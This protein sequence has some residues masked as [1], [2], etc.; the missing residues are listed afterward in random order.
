MLHLESS[1]SFHIVP[2][3]TFVSD[4]SLAPAKPDI[5]YGAPPKDLDPS[6]R[7]ELGDYIIPSTM[8]NKPLVPNFFT[9]IKGPDGSAA[10]MQRQARY[11]GAIGARGIHSLYNYGNNEPVYDG[12][13]YTFS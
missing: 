6:I 12:K 7:N 13:P 11:N 2:S 9:E 1:R 8:E 4:S 3:S 5:Y 10:V